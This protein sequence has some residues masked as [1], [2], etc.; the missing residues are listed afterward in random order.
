MG[1]TCKLFFNSFFGWGNLVAGHITILH[2]SQCD[3]LGDHVTWPRITFQKTKWFI[4]W[5]CPGILPWASK[6]TENS[7]LFVTLQNILVFSWWS[8]LRHKSYASAWSKQKL[9]Y[10]LQRYRLYI[11]FCCFRFCFS[12]NYTDILYET[13]NENIEQNW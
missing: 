6:V 10:N 11:D 13:G 12:I 7:A 4:L 5:L 3:P 2:C 1:V 9:V 8:C